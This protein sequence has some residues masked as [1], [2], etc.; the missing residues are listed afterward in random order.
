MNDGLFT[1]IYY[2]SGQKYS[3]SGDSADWS[4]GISVTDESSQFFAMNM[5]T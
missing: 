2:V 3:I 5:N 1:H 4:V